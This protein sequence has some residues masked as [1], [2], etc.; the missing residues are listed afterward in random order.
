V[1]CGSENDG[2]Q[3][4]ACMALY[5]NYENVERAGDK[6]PKKTIHLVGAKI[7]EPTY[8]SPVGS[9]VSPGSGGT[10]LEKACQFLV[11][12]SNEVNEFRSESGDMKV[13]WLKL[14]TLLTMFPYSVIPEEPSSNPIS[15]GFRYKLDP[16]SYGA[17]SAWAVYIMPEEVGSRCNMLGVH[18]LLLRGGILNQSVGQL[19]IVSPSDAGKPI[20]AWDRDK[21]RRT[22]KTGNLVFIEIGRRCQGGPGLV[23]MYAGFEEA[24]PLRETL[25]RFLFQ[26]DGKAVSI[27][28]RDSSVYSRPRSSVDMSLPSSYQRSQSSSSFQYSQVSVDDSGFKDSPISC[29]PAQDVPPPVRLDKH[30]SFRKQRSVPVPRSSRC[31]PSPSG[32]FGA[33][34]QQSYSQSVGSFNDDEMFDE[35]AMSRQSVSPHDE[36]Y[37][38]ENEESGSGQFKMDPDFGASSDAHHYET[39]P[40]CDEEQHEYE[41]M[42]HPSHSGHDEAH[43]D[44]I[45]MIPA[46]AK[47]L[48]IPR[49]VVPSNYDVPPPFRRRNGES[50][51]PSSASPSSNYENSGPLPTIQEAP[52][53]REQPELYENVP[54]ASK[55][56]DE[57]FVV[58]HPNY[59]NAE[60]RSERRRDSCETYQ[61]VTL[62]DEDLPP[63][64]FRG[65]TRSMEKGQYTPPRNRNGPHLHYAQRQSSSA[66]TM[67]PPG[68][69]PR[70]PIVGPTSDL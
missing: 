9:Q 57:D 13:H 26:G 19:Q 11:I 17:D 55:A 40:P 15:E 44:Y 29:S 21:M 43:E 7:E 23:W 47:A 4:S 48:T 61:N 28:T 6:K 25:H 68:L 2:T 62:I 51:V 69:P 24:H 50:P 36:G 20:V 18:I 39:M 56:R 35:R 5:D 12:H 31:S 65:R 1:F 58:Y 22:G 42:R 66:A 64:P 33:P 60:I 16:K 67:S 59:E 63:Q 45:K 49:P 32:S 41:T 52:K 34:S 3:H 14:L 37:S 8:S 46:I 70:V 27:P 53:T 30:P 54:A 10:P 38:E